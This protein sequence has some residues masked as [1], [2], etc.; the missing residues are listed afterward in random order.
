MTHG[1]GGNDSNETYLMIVHVLHASGVTVTAT[2]FHSTDA[3]HQRLQ[4][5]YIRVA[6]GGKRQTWIGFPSRSV[7]LA[8][9]GEP[10]VMAM[11]TSCRCC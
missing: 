4:S 10:A 11:A 2:S 6:G 8:H 1:A 5:S 9:S 7:L 3:I